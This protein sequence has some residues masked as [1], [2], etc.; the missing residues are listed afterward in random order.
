M[1]PNIR[2]QSGFA[3]IAAVVVLTVLAGMGAFMVSFSNTQQLSAAS[4]IQGTRA[5]WAARAGL[6]WAF[7]AITANPSACPSSPPATVDTGSTFTLTIT[8]TQ[9]RYQE[10]TSPLTVFVLQ[11]VASTSTVGTLGF[12]ERSLSASVEVAQ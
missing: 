3:A 6:E 7:G 9:N 8:C 11:S 2:F 12:V 10:G 5:Y 4:D 1:I